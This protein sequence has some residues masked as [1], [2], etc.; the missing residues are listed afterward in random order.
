M[1]NVASA[2]EAELKALS[3]IVS[4][5]EMAAA[6]SRSNV[7]WSSDAQFVVNEINSYAEPCGWDTRCLVIWESHYCFLFSNF[8]SALFDAAVTDKLGCGLAL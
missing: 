7:I 4:G 3:F 6:N 8:P 1:E 2:V 5:L